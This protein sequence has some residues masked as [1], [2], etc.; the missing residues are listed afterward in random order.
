MWAA[1]LDSYEA[2]MREIEMDPVQVVMMEA[3]EDFEMVAKSD[4]GEAGH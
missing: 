3:A 1:Q 4:T 2:A